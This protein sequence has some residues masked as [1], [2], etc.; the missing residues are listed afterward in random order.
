MHT[1]S[2]V[3]LLGLAVKNTLCLHTELLSRNIANLEL[4]NTTN[5]SY[6]E[7]NIAN[8]LQSSKCLFIGTLYYHIFKLKINGHCMQRTYIHSM[9]GGI[10]DLDSKILSISNNIILHKSLQDFQQQSSQPSVDNHHCKCK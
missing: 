9:A 10:L 8:T 2:D 6:N 5:F 7:K 4:S 3:H 1:Q